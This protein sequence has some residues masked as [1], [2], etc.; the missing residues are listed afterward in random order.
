LPQLFAKIYFHQ[1]PQ[2]LLASPTSVPLTV[3]EAFLKDHS[4][5]YDLVGN[6]AA[7]LIKIGIPALMGYIAGILVGGVVAYAFAP[8]AVAIVVSVFAGFGMDK[9]DRQ[10][11]LAQKLSTALEMLGQELAQKREQIQNALG[12]A[13]HEI[14][15]GIV[16]RRFGM[17]ID[18]PRF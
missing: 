9:I 15:R 2:G 4:S 16:W 12:R 10:Y 6:I 1:M 3:L 17:D 14:K 13:P 5:C 8:I 7:D 11:Q 18:N